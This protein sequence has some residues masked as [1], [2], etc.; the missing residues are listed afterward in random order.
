MVTKYQSDTFKQVCLLFLLATTRKLLHKT[1]LGSF[2][3]HYASCRNP[4]HLSNL[5]SSSESFKLV[6]NLL[7]YHKIL[8]A[9]TV[10]KALT[11]FSSF[12]LNYVKKNLE[13]LLPSIQRSKELMIFILIVL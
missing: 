13:R 11:Q 10:D 2:I 1:K 12:I 4:S 7:V 8:L 6:I 9:K 3:M 5:A